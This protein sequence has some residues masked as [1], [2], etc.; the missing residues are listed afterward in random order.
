MFQGLTGIDDRYTTN[1]REKPKTNQRHE[2]YCRQLVVARTFTGAAPKGAVDR[3]LTVF[4]RGPKPVLQFQ[5][6]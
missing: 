2:E 3:G 1:Q 4:P 5:G 6:A